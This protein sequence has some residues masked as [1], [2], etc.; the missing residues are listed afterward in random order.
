LGGHIF[1][2]PFYLFFS[3]KLTFQCFEFIFKMF[4]CDVLNLLDMGQ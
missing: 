3:F 1:C 4:I 2:T